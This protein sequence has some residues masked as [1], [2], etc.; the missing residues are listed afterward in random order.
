MRND[1]VVFTLL[2]DKGTNQTTN[3]NPATGAW[4]ARMIRGTFGLA[5]WTFA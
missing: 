2:N 3:H 1:Y 5:A 4:A